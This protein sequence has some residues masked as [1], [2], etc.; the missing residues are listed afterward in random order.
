MREQLE[1]R[2]KEL[3]TEF[4]AGQQMLA[5][6]D[7]KRTDLQHTLLRIGGAIQV[8]GELLADGG[9]PAPPTAP[10]TAGPSST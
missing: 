10:N 4:E 9:A 8:L 1:L 2:L 6:L 3:T 7:T 5:E